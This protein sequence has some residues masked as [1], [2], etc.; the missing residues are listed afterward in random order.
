MGKKND[1]QHVAFLE[2]HILNIITSIQRNLCEQNN[3]VF[4][5]NVFEIISYCNDCAQHL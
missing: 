5:F 4:F 3:T 1:N 2:N